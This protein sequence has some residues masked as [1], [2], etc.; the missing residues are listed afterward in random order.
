MSIENAIIRQFS[1]L[2]QQNLLANSED[3]G[4]R[5]RQNPAFEFHFAGR[6]AAEIPTPVMA[7]DAH[8]KIFGDF[9][10]LVDGLALFP[11]Q[12]PDCLFKAMI[13]VVLDQRA[14]CLAY[15]FFDGMK[16]LGNIKT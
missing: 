12:G 3:F 9:L 8:S 11:R 6:I 14:L 1:V 7:L 13:E 15:G 5:R 2:Q 4:Q 16:L 10:E